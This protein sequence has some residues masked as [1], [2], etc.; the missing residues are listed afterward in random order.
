MSSNVETSNVEVETSNVET[1]NVEVIDQ[2]DSS[3]VALP[4]HEIRVVRFELYPKDEPTCYCVGFSVTC[5][6]Q[7]IYRDTQVSLDQAALCGCETEIAQN[8]YDT[9]KDSL[10]SW[11]QQA[12][13]KPA[14]L[15]STF[16]PN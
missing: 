12:S 15:G 16:V 9:L 10:E 7:H 6:N 11:I 5:N 4:S 14:I 2:V 13:A 3:N 8:A 1:S